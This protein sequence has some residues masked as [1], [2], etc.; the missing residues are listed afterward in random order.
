VAGTLV[1][2]FLV[3][4][5]IVIRVGVGWG[6]T[7]EEH[8]AEMPGDAFFEDRL[9]AYVV[10]TRGVSIVAP[11]EVV[12]PWLAQLGRGAGWYSYDSLDNGGRMSARHIVSWIPSPEIGD[13]SPIGYLR[14][15]EP[16][17]EL[18]WWVPKIGYMGASARLAVDMRLTPMGAGSRLVIRMSADAEGRMAQPALWAFRFIDSIMARRQLLGILNRVERHGARTF[19]PQNPEA[20]RDQFQLYEVIYASGEKAGKPGKELAERWREAAVDAGLVKRGR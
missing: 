7:A 17:Q 20:T 11:P 12:W 1:V 4:A 10:M 8:S 5:A 3:F 6:A 9:P 14:H 2:L 18:A 16:G 15:I 19:D 13:A